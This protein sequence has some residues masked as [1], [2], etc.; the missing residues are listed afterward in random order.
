VVKLRAMQRTV[1][2][3][4]AVMIS[5]TVLFTLSIAAQSPPAYPKLTK[6]LS[7]KTYINSALGL[8]L[9]YPASYLRKDSSLTSPPSKRK[10]SKVLLYATTGA[11]ERRCE[12]HGECDEFGTLVVALDPQPFDLK[13]IGQHYEHTGWV[14][15]VPF[16]VGGH[17]FYYIGAGGGGVRYPDTFFYKL[18]GRTLV[19]EFSGPYPPASK[20]PS[21]ETEGIEK[22]VLESVHLR[23][24]HYSLD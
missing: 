21:E 11:G 5:I 7:L 12:D 1:T 19:I 13:T 2:G 20:S 24:A 4:T 18:H 6:P 3:R 23:G 17:T 22:I 15:A 14:E 9:S 8:E 10:A 16:H